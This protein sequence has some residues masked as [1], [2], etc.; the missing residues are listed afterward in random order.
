MKSLNP[1]MLM[2]ARESRGLS[3]T[4]AAQCLGVTQGTLSK[5]ESGMLLPSDDQILMLAKSL[6][7]PEDFFTY[8]ESQ[9]S[10]GTG[11]QDFHFMYRKQAKHSVKH[12]KKTE[13][14]LNILRIRIERLLRQADLEPAL[15][16][17]ALTISEVEG[18]MDLAAAM[19]RATWNM[20]SGPVQN[21]MAW[22]EDAGCIVVPFNFE[23][24]KICATTIFN[25]NTMPPLIFY[26]KDM[27]ADRMRFTLAHELGHIVM[28][29]VPNIEMETQA[30]MFASAFLL[31]S[32]DV[33]SDLKGFSLERAILLKK[34]WKVSIASLAYRAKQLEVISESKYRN[35]CIDIARRGWKMEE[36]SYTHFSKES[37]IL[38]NDLIDMY[39]KNFGY[40]LREL[41]E[42]LWATPEEI[43]EIKG[44]DYQQ[45]TKLK[46]LV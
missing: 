30:N 24:E 12:M 37:P 40:S 11:T 32:R 6:D 4:D 19:V 16:L 39:T 34:K 20:P 26:N 33:Y 38:L 15:T 10:Y 41:S 21:L 18:D 13:A 14:R 27:S 36:P 44:I 45:K 7:Y 22:L 17:P 5:I 3:Q 46:I 25:R 1:E 23:S 43:T 28:H 29:S 9:R 31:P 35:I 2:L 42:F 8:K